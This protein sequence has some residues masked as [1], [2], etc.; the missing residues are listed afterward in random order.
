MRFQLHPLHLLILGLAMIPPAR[1]QLG[2]SVRWSASG[3]LL[4]AVRFGR[5][6]EHFDPV[7]AVRRL[8]ALA[9]VG[10]VALDVEVSQPG[11]VQAVAVLVQ[12]TGFVGLAVDR[13]VEATEVP[14]AAAADIPGPAIEVRYFLLKDAPLSGVTHH[15][16]ANDRTVASEWQ[17]PRPADGQTDGSW[18]GI[19]LDGTGKEVARSLHGSL[20]AL[21]SN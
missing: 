10:G 1:C 5:L 9:A 11:V 20:S 15:L 18:R 14:A 3:P 17:R 8:Y 19:H 6:Q 7:Q 21:G 4:V 12:P 13:W 16:P 2:V